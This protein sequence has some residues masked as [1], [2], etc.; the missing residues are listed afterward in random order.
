MLFKWGKKIT[1]K[2]LESKL[3]ELNDKMK[4]SVKEYDK[5]QA[6]ISA[7]STL[8]SGLALIQVHKGETWI[9]AKMESQKKP[10]DK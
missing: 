10:K 4:F 9:Y 3:N 7:D 2:E 1:T 6:K 8:E 5:D